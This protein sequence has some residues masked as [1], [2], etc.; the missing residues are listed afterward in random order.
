LAYKESCAPIY[1]REGYKRPFPNKQIEAKGHYRAQSDHKKRIDKYFVLKQAA[2]PLSFCRIGR[3]IDE[4]I[5]DRAIKDKAIKTGSR[6][7]T[8]RIGQVSAD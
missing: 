1:Q 6:Q 2:H 5:N 3:M 8:R 4:A 7:A